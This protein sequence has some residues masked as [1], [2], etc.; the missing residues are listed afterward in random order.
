VQYVR[1]VVADILRA[2]G[3]VLSFLVLLELVFV[4]EAIGESLAP[5]EYWIVW[6]AAE[7]FGDIVALPF[8]AIVGLFAR[9][10]TNRRVRWF[11]QETGPLLAQLDAAART[12]TS[13]PTPA[14]PQ[15]ASGVLTARRVPP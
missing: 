13:P 10:A 4:T 14:D 8:L 11:T 5:W 6:G 9:S 3:W 1:P 12:L 15:A 2:R 7:L